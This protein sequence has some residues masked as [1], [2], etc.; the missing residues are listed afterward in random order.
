MATENEIEF[1]SRLLDMSKVTL[2]SNEIGTL[3]DMLGRKQTDEEFD[4][5]VFGKACQAY[6]PKDSKEAEALLIAVRRAQ[7]RDKNGTFEYEKTALTRFRTA[8]P[9]GFQNKRGSR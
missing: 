7:G 2:N 4:A 9:Q 3:Q 8:K 1:M 6:P 5:F